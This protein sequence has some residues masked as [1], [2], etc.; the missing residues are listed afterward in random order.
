MFKKIFKSLGMLAV[1]AQ[2]VEMSAEH[3]DTGIHAHTVT[4]SVRDLN[5]GVDIYEP[6]DGLVCPDGAVLNEDCCE[7]IVEPC[8]EIE[9]PHDHEWW[10]P[11]TCRCECK[12]T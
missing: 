8:I 11:E 3:T 7:C 6:C 5:I 12:L 9:C 2:A 10:N 1:Y 4:D